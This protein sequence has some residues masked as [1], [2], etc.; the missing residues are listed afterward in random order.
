MIRMKN[1]KY[2]YRLYEKDEFYNLEND[3]LELCNEIDNPQYQI[4]Y[5]R[6][7]NAYADMVC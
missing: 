2:V 5:Y 3:P 4:N 6:N 1:Y 7:E